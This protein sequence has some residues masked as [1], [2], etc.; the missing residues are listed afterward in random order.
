MESMQKEKNYAIFSKKQFENK[1][2][3][4]NGVVNMPYIYYK[5]LD[6]SIVMVTEIY[7]DPNNKSCF[8]D[9]VYIGEVGEFYKATATPLA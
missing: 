5:K 4:N 2:D 8:D 6:G 3:I 7:H 9:A 1:V